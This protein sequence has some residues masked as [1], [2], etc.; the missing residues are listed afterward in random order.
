MQ[1][2]PLQTNDDVV[3]YIE[4][5]PHVQVIN[6]SSLATYTWI[7]DNDVVAYIELM[8]HV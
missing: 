1:I 7:Q 6:D 2:K 8:P 4:L 3:A 5:K